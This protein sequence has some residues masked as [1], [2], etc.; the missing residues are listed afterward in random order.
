ME[1]SRVVM[2]LTNMRRGGRGRQRESGKLDAA[3]CSPKVQK[4][5]KIIFVI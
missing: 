3:N 5:A 4:N 1:E 2:F